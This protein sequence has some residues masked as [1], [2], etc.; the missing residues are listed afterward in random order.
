MNLSSGDHRV[1]VQ[2][3]IDSGSSAQLGEAEANASIGHGAVTIEEVRMI[4]N[5]M[6]EF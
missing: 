6:V 4:K 5:D 1:E 2:A 3:R